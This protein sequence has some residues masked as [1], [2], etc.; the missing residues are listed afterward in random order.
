[1][2]VKIEAHAPPGSGK[3]VV[4]NKIFDYVRKEFGVHLFCFG[5]SRINDK[6]WIEEEGQRTT[7]VTIHIII[8][9]PGEE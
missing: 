6:R 9:N 7:P 1:M 5:A 2:L 4:L 8:S 3:S